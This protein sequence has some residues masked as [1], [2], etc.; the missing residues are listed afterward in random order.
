M[1]DNERKEGTG[2]LTQVSAADL[3]AVHKM[4][5]G[6]VDINKLVPEDPNSARLANAG[7]QELI[8]IGVLKVEDGR[9]KKV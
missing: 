7:L 1:F 2:D 4:I 6:A 8:D 3:E 5:R 9:I